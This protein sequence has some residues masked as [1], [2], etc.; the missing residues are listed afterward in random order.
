MTNFYPLCM[1]HELETCLKNK[2]VRKSLIL[3]GKMLLSAHSLYQETDA[4]DIEQ[5]KLVRSDFNSLSPLQRNFLSLYQH[6]DALVEKL[7][8]YSYPILDKA[9]AIKTE[10]VTD[11]LAINK[12]V[13]GVSEH[14]LIK[15]KSGYV[16]II[17]QTKDNPLIMSELSKERSLQGYGYKRIDIQP[18]ISGM[19]GPKEACETLKNLYKIDYSMNMKVDNLENMPSIAP[20]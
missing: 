12:I 19:S 15:P 4:C 1:N 10:N 3:Y 2:F 16:V 5:N 17:S 7:K 6:K 20:H 18:I 14:A 13:K 11:I 8:K 9:I